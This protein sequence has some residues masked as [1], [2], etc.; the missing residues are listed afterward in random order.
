MTRPLPGEFQYGS[1]DPKVRDMAKLKADARASLAV[2]Y[3]RPVT[4]TNE[5]VGGGNDGIR[6]GLAKFDAERATTSGPVG[7]GPRSTFRRPRGPRSFA[8]PARPPPSTSR[9]RTCRLVNGSVGWKQP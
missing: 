7:S 2:Y 6:R 8:A 1:P 9:K 4:Y 3:S 5:S